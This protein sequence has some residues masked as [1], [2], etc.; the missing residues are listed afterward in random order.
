L[1]AWA[2]AILVGESRGTHLAVMTGPYLNRLLDG[3][4][5]IESRFTKHRIAPFDQVTDGDVVFFK[6]AAG[7]VTAVGLA[8]SVQNLDLQQVSLQEIADTY[9]SAIAPVDSSFWNERAH[10]R[11][12]TL[13]AMLSVISLPPL[14]VQKRDRRG[15]VVLDHPWQQSLF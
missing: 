11:Y 7:P 1:E 8:G 12:V 15:W 4:K 9:G 3:T 6:Q 5:T 14:A 10:A 13:V 2:A